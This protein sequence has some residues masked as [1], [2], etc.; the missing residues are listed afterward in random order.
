MSDTYILTR[1]VLCRE[2]ELK[3][4][5]YKCLVKSDYGYKNIYDSIE[6]RPITSNDI[7]I[8]MITGKITSQS[9]NT[10]IKNRHRANFY[11]YRY[12]NWY[13]RLENNIVEISPT[14]KDWQPF[15][16]AIL[17][18]ELEKVATKAVKHDH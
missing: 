15:G 6:W 8:D 10:Y 16:W 3:S 13:Y 12:R 14:G 17:K 7:L 9:I 11:D 4:L 2:K 5:K 18:K 1:K